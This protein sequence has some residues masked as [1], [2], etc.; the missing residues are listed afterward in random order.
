MKRV[1]TIAF[2]LLVASLVLGSCL[3]GKAQAQTPPSPP[4]TQESTKA[5]E[6]KPANQEG[7][8][9][10]LAPE[11]AAPLPAGMTGSDANDPR[12]KLAPGMYDAAETSMGI[13]HVLLLKKPEAFQL[14]SDDPDNPKVQKALG[15]LGVGES[16]KM[17]KPMQLVMAQLAFANSDLA[18]QGNHLFQGNFYGLNIYDI[19]NPAKTTLLTSMVCPGGQGDPSVYKNLLFMSVEMPNGRL[20]CG[21]EGFPPEPQPPAKAEK[22]PTLPAAQKDRFRGVR[23]FDIADVKNPK[24]LAAVQT[25]RGSHTHTLVVDPSDKDNVY[26]YVSGTSFVRQT[27]ELAGCSGEPPDKDPNTALF[28]IEVIKVPLAAPQNAQVVSSPRVFIDP[29]TGALNSLSSGGTHGKNGLEKPQDSDQCHDITVY[30]EIGLA[31]GACSGNGILLD[32]K[33]PVH[34]K[35][36][37]A[38]NDPNYAYWHSASF[39]NDGTKIVFTDEW[40]GGM[41]ARCRA[42]DPNKWGADAVFR[43]KDNKLSFASYYKLPAAQADSENCVAHNG[44]LIP[45][46]GRDIEVQAWYQGGISVMDFTDAEHPVEIAYFDRGPIDPKML[47]LGGHWSAYWYNGHIY[48]SEIARGLDIFELTPTQFLTQNEIDAAKAVRVAELNVQNQ[49]KIEWPRQLVVAKAYVDQL[50]RSRALPADRI[51]ALRQAIQSAESSQMKRRELAKLKSLAPSLEKS[52]AV[53]KSA[54]D[55]TRLQ[56]LAEILKRPAR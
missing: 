40:G 29:R 32:I 46:P 12:A 56:A 33:D 52:G 3:A 35:R 41:G 25:C 18:F 5:P 42:N 49:E 39:S 51:S 11:S 48:A 34:P 30:S 8:G 10:P 21:T 28:R 19:S 26:I 1:P 36:L 27:E 15:L 37:D 20:D 45:V 16:T 14:G 17:P 6:T 23:I 54:A 9:N 24:Q 43:L 2:C 4:P 44:S 50:E 13:K 47:V 55:S 53:T 7:G 22:K 38:V 31:A